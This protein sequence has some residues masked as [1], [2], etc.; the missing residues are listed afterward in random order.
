MRQCIVHLI[1]DSFRYVGRHHGDGIVE[2]LKPIYTA[3][4]EA[5]AKDRF[6]EFTAEWGQR[7]PAVV[8]LWESSWAEFA[9]FVGYGRRNSSSHLYD[10]RI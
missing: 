4:S 10:Q 9:P 2:A 5:A 7:C 8:K 6:E 3:P 1:H